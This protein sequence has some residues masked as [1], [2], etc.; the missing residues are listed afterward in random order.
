MFFETFVKDK[1]KMILFSARK[2]I[3][4]IILRAGGYE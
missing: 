4:T 3:E 1:E 2:N